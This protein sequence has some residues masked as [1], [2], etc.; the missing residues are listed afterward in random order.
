[1]ASYEKRGLIDE[2][3]NMCETTQQFVYMGEN[4]VGV[5]RSAPVEDLPRP[6]T[7]KGRDDWPRKGNGKGKQAGYAYMDR[8]EAGYGS[9]NW[10]GNRS[11]HSTWNGDWNY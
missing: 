1:M 8:N 3:F 7:T 10:D 4:H 2:V 9:S 11:A 6:P 5:D